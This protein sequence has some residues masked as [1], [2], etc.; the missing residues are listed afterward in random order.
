M[1]SDMRFLISASIPSSSELA[2]LLAVVSTRQLYT[3]RLVGHVSWN[4]CLLTSSLELARVL[5][6][7]A[8][9]LAGKFPRLR[10]GQSFE[11]FLSSPGKA[12]ATC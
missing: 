2:S 5:A 7:M 11:C 8:G 9:S 3:A 10:E 6:D 1:Q 12:S 4:L